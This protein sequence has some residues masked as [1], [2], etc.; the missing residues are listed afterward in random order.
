MHK[1]L[2]RLLFWSTGLMAAMA[3]FGIMWLTVV[4]VTGRKFFNNS[5]PGGL[6]ITEVLM[7][8]VIFGALPL[9]SWRNE[10]VVFDSLD[11]LIPDWFKGIQA[12]LI[13]LV[14][15]GVFAY[16]ARLLVQRAERFA[17]Y[18]DITAYLMMPVA[19]VAYLM[20]VLLG[21]TALAHLVQVLIGQTNPRE[22]AP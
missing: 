19:P 14:C 11:A 10:H 1:I 21:V 8:V 22:L 4:D 13:H 6:E 3:L 5:V 2:D 7:V 17:E 16:L 9:V 12:R 20:A 18:G 15:A